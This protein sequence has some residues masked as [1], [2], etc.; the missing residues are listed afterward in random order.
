MSFLSFICT[1]F[2]I[3]YDT[4]NIDEFVIIEGGIN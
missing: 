1:L 3:L 2:G 4:E